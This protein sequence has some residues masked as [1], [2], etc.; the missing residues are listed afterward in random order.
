MLTGTIGRSLGYI[1][2]LTWGRG[3][4]RRKIHDT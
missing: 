2:D 3:G 4:E 1:G